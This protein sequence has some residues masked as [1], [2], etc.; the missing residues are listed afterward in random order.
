VISR[1]RGPSSFS[2]YRPGGRHPSLP[3]RQP[4]FAGP[5]AMHGPRRLWRIC[6]PE[7]R[8]W[9]Q[10]PH[11]GGQLLQH[12][13]ITYPLAEGSDDGGIRDTGDCPTYL[14]EAGNERPES[15]PGFLPYCM[16]VC[17]HTMLLASAGKVR[18]K[19]HTELFS[20]VDGSWGLVHEPSPGW[21]R[22]G[23]MEVGRHHGGVSSC[24]RNGGDINLQEF[25]RVCRTVV[26]F[27]QVW[28][29]LGWPCRRA[30][31]VC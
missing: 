7:Q 16:E 15:L 3:T 18:H 13:L 28:P 23:Y 29:K 20:G 11:H 30:E 27:W 9:G 6:R 31:M 12:F 4:R 19:P 10:S 1:S 5:S 14:G 24:R 8:A 2:S 22:Q 25:R 26:L 17:L 21:S